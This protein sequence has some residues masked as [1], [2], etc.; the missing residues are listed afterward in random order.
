[1]NYAQNLGNN[2]NGYYQGSSTLQKVI[3]FTVLIVVLYLVY[4]MFIKDNKSKNLLDDHPGIQSMVIQSDTIP[5]ASISDYTIS[6]WIYIDQWDYGYG[7]E[8]HILGRYYQ[9]TKATNGIVNKP[10]P[11]ITL[12]PYTNDLIV[13]V[14]YH[15]GEGGSDKIKE[16]TVKGIPLQKWTCITM[17]VSNRTLDVYLDGKLTRTCVIP[18]VPK[19]GGSGDMDL[20]VGPTNKAGLDVGFGGHITDLK[21]FTRAINPTQAYDLYRKGNSMNGLSSMVGKYK[22]KFA[23][24]DNNKETSKFVFPK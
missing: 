16:C 7:K 6:V 1:M 9:D 14:S 19:S 11:S 23:L 8:K 24:L 13:K 18:G 17:A 15:D 4:I 5:A 21:I 3:G 22:F 20:F 2:V 12:H 10:A